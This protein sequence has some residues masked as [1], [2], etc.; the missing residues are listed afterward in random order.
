MRY[1]DGFSFTGLREEP[2]NYTFAMHENPTRRGRTI[3][4]H[5]RGHA[6]LRAVM[7]DLLE[8]E[9]MKHASEV[10]VGGCSAGG[11]AAYQHCVRK[12]SII[13]SRFDVPLAG[14]VCG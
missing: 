9:G 4:I 3:T 10:V 14:Y 12:L 8:T 5:L 13:L 6:V 2:Y 7:D 11:L 1:C